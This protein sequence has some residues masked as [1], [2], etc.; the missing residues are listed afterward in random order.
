MRLVSKEFL[1]S[2]VTL[3]FV[4]VVSTAS[5]VKVKISQLYKLVKILYMYMTVIIF[6]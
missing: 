4:D 2:E 3:L 5:N 6:L 1:F